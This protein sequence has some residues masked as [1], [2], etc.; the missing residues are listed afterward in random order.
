VGDG[1]NQGLAPKEFNRFDLQR[2]RKITENSGPRLG[3]DSRKD[4]T[5]MLRRKLRLRLGNPGRV[6][7]PA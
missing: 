4:L 7:R 1:F 2:R 3:F 6:N 5:D